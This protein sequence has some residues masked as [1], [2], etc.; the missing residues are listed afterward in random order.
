M[1]ILAVAKQQPI[2]QLR[3]QTGFTF[4]RAFGHIPDVRKRL[5]ELNCPAAGIVDV[6]GT[7]GHERWQRALKSSDVRPLYGVALPVPTGPKRAPFAWVLA[8]GDVG[9]LYAFASDETR[10]WGDVN[11]DQIL[12]F[13]G[14]A[15][16]D[17]DEFDY[18][19]LAPA[20]GPLLGKR[21][22]EL[23]KRTGKPLIVTSSNIY[24]GP[25]DAAAAQALIDRRVIYQPAHIATLDELR[26]S[27]WWVPRATF[28]AAVN[29]TRE[30]AERCAGITLN[31][32]P[33]IHV[34]GDIKAE[35]E[36]GRLYRLAAGHIANWTAEYQER[37]DHE[38]EQIHLKDYESY[39]LIVGDL[40]RWAKARMLVGPARGS[41]AGSLVCYLLRITEVDPLVHNLLFQRFIDVS[42][43]D[44]PDIDIDFQDD[45]RHLVFEYLAQRYGADNV[46]RLG[47]IST[48]QPKS[49]L[50]TCGDN[51]GIYAVET[52]AVAN[53]LF[54][55]SSGDR[56]YGKALQDTLEQTDPGIRFE[57]M[58]PEF[59]HAVRAENHPWHTSVHAAAA[60]VC[61][62]PLT[63]FCTVRNGIC[64]LDKKSAEQLGLLKID[65]LGLRTL[66]VIAD[67]GC[68]TGEDLY[69]LKLDDPAAFAVFN[70]GKFAGVFQFEGT[71]QR[72][73]ATQIPVEHFIQ[74]DHITALA[75]PGPLGSGAA[76]TYIARNR[77]TKPIGYRHPSMEPYLHDTKGV[78]L[79]QEQVMR[80]CREIGGFGWAEVAKIRKAMSASLGVE[81]FRQLGDTFAEGAARIHGLTAEASAEIWDEICTFGGWGMNRSH[82]VSYGIIAY[83]CAYMKAYHALDYAAALL[84]RASGDDQA[85]E[86]LRELHREGIKIVAF[87]PDESEIDWSI[88]HGMLYGGWINIHGIGPKKAQQILNRR[89]QGKATAKDREVAISGKVKFAELWPIRNKY[90]KVYVTP[91][92]LNCNT[93]II[94]V[95]DAHDGRDHTFILQFVKA[96][97]RDKNEQML[98]QKRNGKVIAGPTLFLDMWVV[99][100][101]VTRPIRARLEPALWEPYGRL[102]ADKAIRR[103]DVFLVRG[104]YLG[105]F[106]M[107]SVKKIRCI[108]NRSLFVDG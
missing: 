33:L 48:L 92:L 93:P 94:E 35:L 60:I 43:N 7:W 79:Y 89:A 28:N 62:E 37:L 55:Y 67:T 24:P 99:D 56:R 49:V 103:Q 10:C 11:P 70:S 2:P 87:D 19:D 77:G 107:I 64:Q 68:V 20:T 47:N 69:G 105:Q 4:R 81:Y 100:D 90:A 102:I 98:I 21:Q 22:L 96:E 88:R 76:N 31:T 63:R 54:E 38:I 26:E 82:T 41:S 58:H 14:C 12:R 61:N 34:K 9:P 17:P 6:D 32:A 97:R 40:V 108:T 3:I 13:A 25:D 51:L 5:D 15:L 42:R 8:I 86:L 84:R 75:R 104:T 30:V 72:K 78:V 52:R 50:T 85:L 36:A 101:S 29:N 73:V 106:S 59:Q 65:A 27:L 1:P 23:A 45:R 80:I 91:A 46:A 57:R 95:S 53:V 66:G 74:I 18:I 83:W 39:F 71:A 16:D 44:L